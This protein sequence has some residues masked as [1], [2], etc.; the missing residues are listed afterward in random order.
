M[1][2]RAGILAVAV[3]TAA[4]AVDGPGRPARLGVAPAVAPAGTGTLVVRREALAAGRALYATADA[5]KHKVVVTGPDLA[6]PFE[7]ELAA[8]GDMRVPGVPMGA[9]RLV[10]FEALDAAGQAMPGARQR[11]LVAVGAGDNEVLL[12]PA[13]TFVGE[14]FAQVMAIDD[15]KGTKVAAGID[16]A[17]FAAALASYPRTLGVAH[18]AQLSATAIADA[19]HA[20]G[21]TPPAAQASFVAATGRVVL[22]PSRWPTGLTAV[23]RLGDPVSAPVVV[24]NRPVEL[25][26]LPPGTWTLVLAPARAGLAPITQAVTVTAGGVADVELRFGESAPLGNMPK[27][28]GAPAHGVLTI[29]GQEALVVLGGIARGE[30]DGSEETPAQNES[31]YGIFTYTGGAWATAGEIGQTVFD[32]A[33]AVQ[34]GKLWVLGGNASYVIDPATPG[35]PQLLP[36][37]PVF[38][39]LEGYYPD[40]TDSPDQVDGGGDN[41]AGA[42]PRSSGDPLETPTPDPYPSYYYSPPPPATETILVGATA[43]ASGSAIY[44]FGGDA[45]Y[46]RLADV[47]KY[48]PATGTW[49]VERGSYTR[50]HRYAMAAGAINGM[51]YFAGGGNALG[52]EY[53]PPTVTNL[54][55]AYL[56]ATSEASGKWRLMAAMPTARAGAASVVANGRLYV[57]GGHD[58]LGRPLPDVESYDPATDSWKVHPPLAQPR[59][60]AA[61]GLVGSKIVVAGGMSGHRDQY[62]TAVLAAAEEVTP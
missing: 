41:A 8:T 33:C 57:I 50:Y 14:V 20:A 18:P 56:P 59:A 62:A 29:G 4:C 9:R 61:A 51:I 17:A 34:G 40:P 52:G 39:E 13:A 6:T 43:V 49:S 32:Q 24:G 3:L 30:A 26:G 21:G 11:A 7:A 15:P 47:L 25:T 12:S 22:R 36:S 45:N 44:L 42:N 46:S 37:V 23:A 53:S 27:A 19:T 48:Q 10:T 35:A 31:N 28:V 1:R 58:S 16:V 54:V 55:T 5:A 38:P 2:L 60:F